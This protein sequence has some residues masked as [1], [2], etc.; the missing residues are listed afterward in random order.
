MTVKKYFKSD[1]N[2]ALYLRPCKYIIVSKTGASGEEHGTTLLE[3]TTW[4][5]LKF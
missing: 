5:G 2:L 1:G 4:H 3:H